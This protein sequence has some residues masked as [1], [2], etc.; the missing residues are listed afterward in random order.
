MFEVFVV[1]AIFADFCGSDIR[2]LLIEAVRDL[3]IRNST[4][5]IPISHFFLLLSLQIITGNL[6]GC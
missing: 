5:I 6:F 4:K 1:Y 3:F 2:V